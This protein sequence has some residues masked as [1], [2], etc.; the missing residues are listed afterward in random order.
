MMDI[1]TTLRW[2]FNN[3]LRINFAAHRETP[4]KDIQRLL[5]E[6]FRENL[7]AR[8]LLFLTLTMDELRDVLNLGQ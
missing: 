8:P 2:L 1:M 7:E 6:V 3:N 5:V 4:K